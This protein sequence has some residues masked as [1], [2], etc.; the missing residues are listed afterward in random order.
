MEFLHIIFWLFLEKIQNSSLKRDVRFQHCH[1]NNLVFCFLIL[2][3]A[4]SKLVVLHM[5]TIVNEVFIVGMN[6]QMG[7]FVEMLEVHVPHI[8]KVN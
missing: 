8:F 7:Q 4:G 1:D 3:R 6:E 5:K 2:L